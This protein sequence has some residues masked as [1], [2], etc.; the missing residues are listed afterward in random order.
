MANTEN[1]KETNRLD[2]ERRVRVLSPGM[3]VFKRFTRNRLAVLGTII[4]VLMFIFSFIGGAISPY[5]ENQVFRTTT[6]E[7]K[8]YAGVRENTDFLYTDAPG[9]ELPKLAKT[10]A[11]LAIN[12]G[13]ES[14]VSQDVTYNLIKESDEFY[15]VVE[16]S[17]VATVT[18]LGN[19]ASF[20]SVDGAEISDAVKEAFSQ[21]QKDGETS[22]KVEGTDYYISGSGRNVTIAVT[23]DLCMINKLIFSPY[24]AETTLDYNFQVAAERAMEHGKTEFTVDGVDYKAD[25]DEKTS[26]AI[27]YKVEGGQETE[28]A[29]A[30]HFTVNPVSSDVFLSIEFKDRVQEAV[31]N[32]ESSFVFAD[33]NG[34]EAEYTVERNNNEYTIKTMK[35]IQVNSNYESP[36]AAHWLGTDGNGMDIL[37]RLM[38]GGRISLLI[39]FLVVILSALIGVVLGG[40]AGY[41]GKWLDN[42][43]MRLVDVF[44]CIPAMPVYLI[45]GSIMD[46]A[47]IDPRL[48][49]WLLMVI[50]SVL[51]WPS[52]ARLTR[53]QILSLREQEFMVATEATGIRVSKRIFKHLIPN[54]MPQLIVSCTMSL[55][56]VIL[57]EATLSFLG[58]GV[59]FPY[60]SWGNMITAVND[61]YVLKT[62]WFVWIPAGICIVLTVLGFNFIGDGLR[63]A[64]DPKMKR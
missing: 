33:A 17:P 39:G 26:S 43:I 46:F 55:G 40:L 1:T 6:M 64:Y 13:E 49:I 61:L 15:R 23:Q 12:N 16:M 47:K 38:Y 8:A 2:D 42:L 24:S 51:S 30:S 25:I 59:K 54:V 3:L 21:A 5:E 4:I 41:F 11:I 60:A 14:F 52:I 7:S 10:Q 28:Y 48:R 20:S 44:N 29:M 9:K 32:N 18:T 45:L 27:F 56:S 58:L 50:L 62:Y 31:K 57:M 35:E 36:S 63:D 53:G 19:V 34:T 37:T 22:F